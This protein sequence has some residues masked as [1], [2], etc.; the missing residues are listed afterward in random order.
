[1]SK[2]PMKYC[3]FQL[4]VVTSGVLWDYK[5][6]MLDLLAHYGFNTK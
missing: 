4:T 2:N 3:G 5:R 1:M 6:W